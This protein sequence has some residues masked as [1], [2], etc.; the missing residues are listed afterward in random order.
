MG[1]S[2]NCTLG[3][4]CLLCTEVGKLTLTKETQSH[5]EWHPGKRLISL[6]KSSLHALWPSWYVFLTLL[7]WYFLLWFCQV[8]SLSAS[9]LKQLISHSHTALFHV[10]NCSKRKRMSK[11][12]DYYQ[13]WLPFTTSPHWG[14]CS[15][16]SPKAECSTWTMGPILS[17]ILGPILSIT[18]GSTISLTPGSTISLTP[19]PILS[20]TLRIILEILP[21]FL[22][23][24]IHI[25]FIHTHTFS[26]RWL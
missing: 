2:S 8:I 10:E 23:N 5:M 12:F 16:L 19:G 17:L 9:N 1:P 26:H 21:F 6:L 25:S 24:C 4:P 13:H 22:N 18:L 14:N 15:S 3:I 11:Y 7:F 20:L